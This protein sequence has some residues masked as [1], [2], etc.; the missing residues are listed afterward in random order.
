MPTSTAAMEGEFEFHSSAKK[1]V[2][3][4]ERELCEGDLSGI[5]SRD[6]ERVI[7]A[8]VNFTPQ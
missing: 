1:L 2:N 4:M 6:L 7:T 3:I 5:Q 8:A